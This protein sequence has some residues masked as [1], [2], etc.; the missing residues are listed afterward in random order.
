MKSNDGPVYRL[1]PHNTF[2]K[3]NFSLHTAVSVILLQCCLFAQAAAQV[4]EW[5]FKVLLN[6]K[7]VGTHS[8]KVAEQDGLWTVQSDAAFDVKILFFNAYS[9]RHSCVETWDDL[10]LKSI[11]STTDANGDDFTVSGNRL[12]DHFFLS[13]RDGEMKLPRE[14]YSFAYWNPDI[15]DKTRLVNAQTGEHEA[16]VITEV[17]SAPIRY[18]GTPLDA[19]RYDIQVKDQ[20]ISV[21]YG[22]DDMRWLALESPAKGG[23]VIRYEPVGLPEV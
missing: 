2:M 1:S 22:A 3:R 4:R 13:N 7:E 20:T 17:P 10:G 8:F 15:L 16:V 11:E 21:W 14:L 23:R 12:D 6:G 18:Q 5:D 9:Y 19:K